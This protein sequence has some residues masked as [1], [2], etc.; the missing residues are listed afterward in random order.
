MAGQTFDAT[1]L[2]GQLRYM[3]W[4]I[5][6]G[7][8]ACR[9]LTEEELRRGLGTPLESVRGLLTHVFGVSW[10][11][12]T[13]LADQE[14]PYPA[15]LDD[16]APVPLA[17]I[18][19]DFADLQAGYEALASRLERPGEAADWAA[20]T[21]TV[22]GASLRRWQVVLQVVGHTTHHLGQLACD[23]R[24]LGRKGAL[25]D[26]IVYFVEAEGRPWPG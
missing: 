15:W 23:L 18:E 17:T 16:P 26:I 4:A 11:F 20:T 19:Q 10:W 25:T 6:R 24:L 21:I 7:L 13:L 14:P 1:N 8:E 2:G 12:Y 9:P 3:A 5:R 22:H